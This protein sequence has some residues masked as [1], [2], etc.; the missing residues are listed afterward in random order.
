MAVPGVN[1][2]N[3]IGPAALTTLPGV[4]PV[5]G[6]TLAVP[7]PVISSAQVTPIISEVVPALSFGDI[8]MSGDMPIGGTIKV[9]GCFPVYGMVAVDGAVPSAGTAYV[10]EAFGNQVLD[11]VGQCARQLLT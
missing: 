9:R 11:V 7:N 8:T 6:T 10:S 1:Y 4:M 5:T 2:A 3:T